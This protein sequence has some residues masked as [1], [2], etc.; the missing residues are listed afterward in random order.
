MNRRLSFKAIFQNYLLK[1]SFKVI[2]Q[3]YF[4]KNRIKPIDTL[5]ILNEWE[6]ENIDA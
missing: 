1:I 2:F 4:Y 6:K 5:D 3:N